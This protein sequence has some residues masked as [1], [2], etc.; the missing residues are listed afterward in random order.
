M[1][2]YTSPDDLTRKGISVILQDLNA[3]CP[4]SHFFQQFSYKKL[5]SQVGFKFGYFPVFCVYFPSGGA[6]NLLHP[7]A[8]H[9][10]QKA[11]L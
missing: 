5:E 2:D 11:C 6:G 8:A 4:H 1:C 7:C 9:E 10:V 3:T